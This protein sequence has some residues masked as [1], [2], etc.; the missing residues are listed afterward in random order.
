M[1]DVR[2]AKR[3]IDL[4]LKTDLSVFARKN[5]LAARS[6]LDRE[7]P[8]FKAPRTLPPMTREEVLVACE[9]RGRGWPLNRPR[10]PIPSLGSPGPRDGTRTAATDRRATSGYHES[11]S[12]W[13]WRLP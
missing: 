12:P 1:S 10:W 5:L 11:N 3:L 4:V 8:E 13:R 6:L 9:L 7:K 2:R